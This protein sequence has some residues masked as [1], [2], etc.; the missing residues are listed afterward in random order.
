MHDIRPSA[1]RL[2][3]EFSRVSNC[4]ILAALLLGLI[5][6]FSGSA[7]QH[8]P[9]G[10]SGRVSNYCL[11]TA[12]AGEG[13]AGVVWLW[14]KHFLHTRLQ[15]R[16]LFKGSSP[17]PS[18]PPTGACSTLPKGPKGGC[19]L[20]RPL[21]SE[22]GLLRCVVPIRNSSELSCCVQDE[23]IDQILSK[24]ARSTAETDIDW[25]YCYERLYT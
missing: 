6:E 19:W 8:P 13:E 4:A 11:L 17:S 7:C 20:I 22:A 1:V 14:R 2:F 23:K 12:I 25:R 15:N 18:V 3:A 5:A 10:P 9:S 16:V 24:E 21:K